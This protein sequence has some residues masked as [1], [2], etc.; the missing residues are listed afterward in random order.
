MQFNELRSKVFNY[1]QNYGY[2]IS[3]KNVTRLTG[4]KL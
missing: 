1:A 2:I 4:K 3:R